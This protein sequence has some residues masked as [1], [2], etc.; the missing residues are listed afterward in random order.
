M[1]IKAHGEGQKTFI[2][3]SCQLRASSTRSFETPSHFRYA[4]HK[5]I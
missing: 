3:V 4:H 1:P 5:S 2:G